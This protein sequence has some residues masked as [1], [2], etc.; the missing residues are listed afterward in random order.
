MKNKGNLH[1][2]DCKCVDC[3]QVV[4]QQNINASKIDHILQNAVDIKPNIAP[5]MNPNIN[6]N[7]GQMI[8]EENKVSGRFNPNEMYHNV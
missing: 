7:V 5:N 6:P 3:V 2:M 1:F 4:P 8:I